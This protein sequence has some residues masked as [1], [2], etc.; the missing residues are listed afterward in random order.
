MIWAVA[1]TWGFS[2]FS[3]HPTVLHLPRILKLLQIAEVSSF[4]V[5]GWEDLDGAVAGT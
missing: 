1:V 4:F 5:A 3:L 2:W